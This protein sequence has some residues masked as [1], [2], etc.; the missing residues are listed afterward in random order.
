MDYPLIDL[1]SPTRLLFE[2]GW[3]LVTGA[4]ALVYGLLVVVF[5]L[6]MLVPLPR[7]RRDV[8]AVE[9]AREEEAP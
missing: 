4:N 9:E 1:A 8:A 3:L 7:A 5:V 2:W 6:G